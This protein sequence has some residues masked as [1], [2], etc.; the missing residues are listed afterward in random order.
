MRFLLVLMMIALPAQASDEV[1]IFGRADTKSGSPIEAL[2]EFEEPQNRPLYKPQAQPKI[3]VVQKILPPQVKKIPQKE[4]EQW[5][6]QNPK[7]FSVTPQE[8]K[9]EIENTL[10]E[11]GGRI[12]DVQSYP[13]K[14]IK[15]ITEPNIDP[16]ISTYPEY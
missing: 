2:V 4:I 16:T 7:P 10:Y 8:Q 15:T 6:K 13:L 11:G 5:S 9:D 1:K 3:P 14:D 12:Y